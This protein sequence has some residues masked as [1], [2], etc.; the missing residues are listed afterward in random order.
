MQINQPYSKAILIL[1]TALAL[2]STSCNRNE[3]P[4]ASPA[5]PRPESKAA[6]TARPTGGASAEKNSFNEVTAHLDAGGS[7]FLYW[8]TEQMLSGLSGKV[9]QLRQFAT[10]FPG[11]SASDA[12]TVGKVVDFVA[13][14]VRNSGLEN[15]SGVGASSFAREAGLYQSR[16]MLHHYKGKGSGY[17]WSLFGK[18]PHALEGA[19]MLP[20][21]TALAGFS[22][23]DFAG[24]WTL[25]QNE[26]SK[27]EIPEAGHALEQM[28]QAFELVTGIKFDQML[29]SL[30]GEY[31]VILTLDDSK[32]VPIPAGG[33]QSL[34]I[35]EPG[36]II[37][38]RV[39]DNTIFDRVEKLLAENEQLK[40][41]IVRVDKPGLKMRTMP[42]PLPLPIVLRPTLARFGD[43]LL[44]ASSD[45][46]IEEIVAVKSGKKPGWKSTDEYK[47]LSQGMPAQGNNFFYVSSK[48][49]QTFL[50]IQNQAM[51]SQ[52]DLPSGQIEWMQ[53]FFGFDRPQFS[54]AVG[55]NTDEGWLTVAN[56]NRDS[57]KGVLA[58][59]AIVPL[60]AAIAVPNF[61]KARE[62]AQKNACINNMRQIEGAK[63][64]WALENKKTPSDVPTESDLFGPSRYIR[65]T[66]NCPAGGHYSINAVGTPVNCSRHGSP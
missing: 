10:G 64:Q 32:K 63:Q 56:A 6:Q 66:V 60:M 20:A 41:Q 65:G 59:A 23:V 47:K 62:M 46:L 11:V 19:E 53:K 58:A 8:S 35:P 9:T 5:A 36:L 42:V 45:V 7:L 27:L 43:Y 44:L 1:A 24:V 3:G 51:K 4:A 54:Y 22:D 38:L 50:D 15:V 55:A 48:F 49:G 26:I 52:K 25:L 2:S 37:A 34:Q 29:A 30:G 40:Q 61:M 13:R 33:G 31:G 12:Q 14:L 21:T 18:S 16:F 28:P 39:K 57:N 17:L